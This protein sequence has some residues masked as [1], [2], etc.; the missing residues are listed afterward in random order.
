MSMERALGKASILSF[1]DLL[2]PQQHCS[3]LTY[4]HHQ[5]AS[6]SPTIT[7]FNICIFLDLKSVSSLR[8]ACSLLN[9]LFELISEQFF[10]YHID[11]FLFGRHQ[12]HEGVLKHLP[13]S[14]YLREQFYSNDQQQGQDESEFNNI[15]ST[16]NISHHHDSARLSPFS[17]SFSHST[18]QF[19]RELLKEFIREPLHDM[20][21]EETDV[22]FKKYLGLG[23]VVRVTL[24]K[25]CRLLETVL[26]LVFN[27]EKNDGNL[28][29][30]ESSSVLNQ[31][32]RTA[33]NTTSSSNNIS[34]TILNN[35]H[36]K[37][38]VAFHKFALLASLFPLLTSASIHI[39]EEHD[40]N[41]ETLRHSTR[42]ID[43]S[44]V[45][46]ILKTT[47][48]GLLS[49]MY[50]RHVHP[51][52]ELNDDSEDEEEIY[53][54]GE[55]QSESDDDASDRCTSPLPEDYF[56]SECFIHFHAHPHIL[57]LNPYMERVLKYHHV[58][59]T[60][61]EERIEDFKACDIFKY[62]ARPPNSLYLRKG[63]EEKM[64]ETLSK[65]REYLFNENYEG[66]HIFD[67]SG[68]IQRRKCWSIYWQPGLEHWGCFSF[69]I[70]NM[71]K[72]FFVVATASESD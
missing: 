11:H 62:C 39:S 4:F 14:H 64:E 35:H 52:D 12:F 40:G 70:F 36:R 3:S 61:H 18:N 59:N 20:K 41:N 49:W 7:L 21:Y 27:V 38:K 5:K 15:H 17:H 63:Q 34:F 45:S 55:Y 24:Y 65:I 54:E 56:N 33:P 51:H 2:Q 66:N 47:P 29:Q 10:S 13:L 8:Q 71:K 69:T 26:F 6:S 37:R 9:S 32:H 44:T 48:G 68:T 42:N 31:Q 53:K 19:F 46:H 43:S 50:N 23:G 67:W 58:S 28:N 60:P 25:P 16:P 22:N 72:K 30:E 57:A 1:I